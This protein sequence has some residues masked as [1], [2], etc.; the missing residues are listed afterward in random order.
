MKFKG[1]KS[2]FVPVDVYKKSFTVRPVLGWNY[3]SFSV[4]FGRVQ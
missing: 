2:L 3:P 4:T 1:E